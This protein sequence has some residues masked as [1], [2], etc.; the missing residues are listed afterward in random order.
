MK[1]LLK[2][3]SRVLMLNYAGNKIE[4]VKIRYEF[5]FDT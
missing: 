2:F 3:W 1:I 5:L 4:A